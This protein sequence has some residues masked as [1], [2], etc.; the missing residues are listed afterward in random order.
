MNGP[1]MHVR[2]LEYR[3]YLLQLVREPPQW[4][5]EITPLR[6]DLPE[7]P[8]EKQIVRGWDEDEV[9]GRAKARVDEL[10]EAGHPQ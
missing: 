5:V 8:P 9:I 10:L 7:L 3:S 6:A 1:K 4:R 2:N